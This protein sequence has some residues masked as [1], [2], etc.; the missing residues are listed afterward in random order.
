MFR[1]RP[2]KTTKLMFIFYDEDTTFWGRWL[3]MK[4]LVWS[5]CA[6]SKMMRMTEIYCVC[7][8]KDSV[9]WVMFTSGGKYYCM[10]FKLMSKDFGLV[11]AR[12]VVECVFIY[13]LNCSIT[14]SIHPSD[15]SFSSFYSGVWLQYY[16]SMRTIISRCMGFLRNH[17]QTFLWVLWV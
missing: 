14:F 15:F 11:L 16:Y 8:S 13:A 6:L 7:R 9:C 17:M 4:D 2:K 10:L 12:F 5:V 3:K 1:T